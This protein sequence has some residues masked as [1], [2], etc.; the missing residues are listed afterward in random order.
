MTQIESE[1][2]WYSPGVLPTELK[3]LKIIP[4]SDVHYGNPYFSYHHFD[5]ALSLLSIP[6]YYTILNGDLCESALKTSKGDIYKQVG[7]PQDQRDWIIKQLLPYKNKILGMTSGNHENR[8]MNDAGIDISKD[9]ASALNVP[10]RAEGIL[11]KVIFGS[12]NN[13][14]PIKPYVYYCYATH[15]YGGART[16]SAKA[17]KVERLA[18]WIDADFYIM[19]HD[20]V[21]NI[22]PEIY[23][24]PDDRGKINGD[25]F[26]SGAIIAK[27]KMLVKSNAFIKWGGYSEAGGFPP[28]DLSIVTIKLSGIGD[29]E[30]HVEV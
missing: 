27:R 16:K 7:S 13:R 17:V 2:R 5:K 25:G 11:L 15:G 30:V 8:I 4:I 10:Y 29:P 14:M 1:L 3:C 20:H 28:V 9:I 21:V 19:S 22:A 23:L 12:G 24:R 18:T 6:E 26:T